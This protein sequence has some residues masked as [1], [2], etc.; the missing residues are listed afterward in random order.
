MSRIVSYLDA[1]E[2]GLT[3]YTEN[4][5]IQEP[6]LVEKDRNPTALEQRAYRMTNRVIAAILEDP[7]V[8]K[9]LTKP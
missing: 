2:R 6:P 1:Q 8:R 9:L 3:V 5:T 7:E 4:F